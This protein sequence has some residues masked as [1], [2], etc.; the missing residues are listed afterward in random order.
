MLQE[1]IGPLSLCSNTLQDA[2]LDYLKFTDYISGS[3]ARR[4]ELEKALKGD[5]D[6]DPKKKK[7]KKKK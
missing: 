2:Y 6:D 4:K 3:E 1:F 7:K 5:E